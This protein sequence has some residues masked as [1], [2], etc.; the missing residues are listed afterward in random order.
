MAMVQ[1]G[2]PVQ[3]QSYFALQRRQAAARRKDQ[4][5]ALV[6][7]W[8]PVWGYRFQGTERTTLTHNAALRRIS[9]HELTLSLQRLRGRRILRKAGSR[10][11]RSAGRP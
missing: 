3:R 10:Y 1:T 4:I 2:R 11:F 8:C 7:S 6:A 9:A 5:D